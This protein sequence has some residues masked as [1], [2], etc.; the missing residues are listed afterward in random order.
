MNLIINKTGNIVASIGRSFI[1]KLENLFYAAGFFCLLIKETFLIIGKKQLTGRLFTL[2]ILFTGI[3]ALGI[4]AVLSLSLGAAIIVQGLALLPMFG[5]GSLI[6]S[7]LITVITK[8]LGPILVA[9]IIIARSS[10]AIATEL[11]NMVVSHEIEAYISTGINPVSYLVV[12]RFLGVTISLVILNIWF[13]I[14]GLFGSYFVTQ[15]FSPIPL[16]DFFHNLFIILKPGDIFSSLIKCLVF[17][18]IISSVATYNGFRVERS[19]TEIPGVVIKS[20]EQG[21]LLCII[22][23]VI[24]TLMYYT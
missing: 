5:Q 4:V 18:I 3:D 19:P 20:V 2:Q 22:A 11:G 10:T 12:P 21:F 9:F 13:N 24:I 23:N 6:Y 7:I 16:D 1:K 8:E 17:G 14:F 15:L